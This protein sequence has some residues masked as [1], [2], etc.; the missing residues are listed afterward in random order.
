MLGLYLFYILLAL[1][2]AVLYY[3]FLSSRKN[4]IINENKCLESNKPKC[5]TSF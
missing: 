1:C 4:I 2:L 3:V 5:F